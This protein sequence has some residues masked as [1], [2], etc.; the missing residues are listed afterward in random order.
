MKPQAQDAI[1][2]Q[3]PSGG[4]MRA[5]PHA[6]EPGRLVRPPRQASHPSSAAAWKGCPD[7]KAGGAGDTQGKPVGDAAGLRS[8]G[9]MEY[10]RLNSRSSDR[11]ALDQTRGRT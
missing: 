10:R 2:I 3:P 1:A 9:Q 8:R 7:C 6:L 4:A 5:V 11:P